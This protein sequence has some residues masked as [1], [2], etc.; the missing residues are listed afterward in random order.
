MFQKIKQKLFHNNS[1]KQTVAKNTFWLMGSEII[2]RLFRFFLIIYVA[3]VLGAE[4]W[5]LFSYALSFIG[6]FL[7][8]SDTGISTLFTK[9]Y[10]GGQTRY[11]KAMIT[12]KFFLVI[13]SGIIALIAGFKLS[14]LPISSIVLPVAIMLLLDSLRDFIATVLRSQEKM[15]LEAL[16]KIITNISLVIISGILVSLRPDSFSLAIGYMSGSIIGFITAIIVAYPALQQL[17]K[18]YRQLTLRKSDII[19]V[20][21]FTLPIA[22]SS[23]ATVI[24][25]NVDTVMLGIWKTATD[26]GWYASAQRIFQ[27]TL[28]IPGIFITALFPTL[29][30]IYSENKERFI[31]IAQKSFSLLF[32]LGTPIAFG[33]FIVA[34]DL[35]K[36][37]FGIEY[38]P[39]GNV[40]AWLILGTFFVFP[41]TIFYTFSVITETQKRIAIHAFSAIF[42]NIIFNAL[43][44]PRYG[45][46]GAAIGTTITQGYLFIINGLFFKEICKLSKRNFRDILIGTILV[47]LFLIVIPKIHVLL[48]IAMSAII[49]LGILFLFKNPSLEMISNMITKKA[50]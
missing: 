48:Q 46:L 22:L 13:V 33:G 47:I 26:I 7:V 5:G 17:L 43:L 12:V 30:K 37:L 18:T 41:G 38:I 24:I 36:L 20:W 21:K 15:E 29:S 11:V 40:F 42:I 4:G 27:F 39:A 9:E 49:Y 6:T 31:K 32:V 23:L 50:D 14:S 8:F 28:I 44:I 45:A 19:H 25:T 1:E 34:N 10:A 16:I 2:V 35:M 3:R